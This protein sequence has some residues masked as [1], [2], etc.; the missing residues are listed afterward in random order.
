MDT[1]TV[2]QMKDFFLC[3]KDIFEEKIEEL[4]A[5]DAAIGDGDHGVSMLKG[6]REVALAIKD[7]EYDDIGALWLDCAKILMKEIGGTCG[8]LFA[9]LFMKGGMLARNKSEVDIKTLA[10]MFIAG[11]AGVKTM[12]KAGPGEKTMV[13]ALEPAAL[14]LDVCAKAEK[15]LGESVKLAAKAASDSA[16]ATADMLAVK[17]RARYQGER[18][19]GHQDAGATS[20]AY[21]F[22][23][24][25]KIVNDR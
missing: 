9:S 7:K 19:L 13:D 20:V 23:V 21:I 14:T 22:A 2:S 24:L 12:G 18:S 25:E 6:Y 3:T 10:E 5:L 17:G 8:P 16:I 11:N 15:P 1:I 4:S